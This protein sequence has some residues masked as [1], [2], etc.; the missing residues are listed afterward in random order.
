MIIVIVEFFNYFYSLIKR[1]IIWENVGDK[2]TNLNTG[3]FYVSCRLLYNF[4]SHIKFNIIP[5]F[6]LQRKS[7][8]DSPLKLTVKALSDGKL[9]MLSKILSYQIK[10][11]EKICLIRQKVTIFDGNIHRSQNHMI[12]TCSVCMFVFE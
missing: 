9:K 4:C 6:D 12:V 1:K 10:Q 11:I 7:R 2:I 5:Q 3:W 8:S